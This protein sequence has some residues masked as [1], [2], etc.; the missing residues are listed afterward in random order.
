MSVSGELDDTASLHRDHAIGSDEPPCALD[1]T[2]RL[3]KVE[4]AQLEVRPVARKPVHPYAAGIIR[5][6]RARTIVDGS[7][8][9]VDPDRAWSYLE[10][11]TPHDLPASARWHFLDLVYF[12]H[13][14][15]NRTSFDC[16]SFQS[17][18]H[19]IAGLIDDFVDGLD[20]DLPGAEP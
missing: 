1:D 16:H 12:M 7:P 14:Q 6:Y 19:M 4:A 9:D 13:Q 11:L 10:N 8:D 15:S 2:N 18:I 5:F 17:R 3:H 20:T